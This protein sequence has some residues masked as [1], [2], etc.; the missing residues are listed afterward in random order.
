MRDTSFVVAPIYY[1][2]AVLAPLR[3]AIMLFF[4]QMVFEQDISQRLFKIA[5]LTAQ[6]LDLTG[7]RLALGVA[8]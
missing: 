8:R 7:C 4:K 2:Q 5:H 6:I 3:G 1:R